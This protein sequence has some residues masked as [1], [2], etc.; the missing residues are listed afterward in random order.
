MGYDLYG[1]YYASDR[2]AMNA[3]MAQCAEIDN[4]I[5]SK[6]LKD[7]ERQMLYQHPE[8]RDTDE[9]LY[10]LWETIKNLEARII[11]LEVNLSQPNE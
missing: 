7:L 3:E 2:D 4:R 1:N 11:K 5:M 8:P 9:Q 10:Y 6:K